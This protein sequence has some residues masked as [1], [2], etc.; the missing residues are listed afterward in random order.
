M[1]IR[2]CGNKLTSRFLDGKTVKE[3]QGIERQATKAVTRLQAAV[4]LSDLRSPPGNNLEALVGD[5]KGQHSIRIND[6]WRLCFLWKPRTPLQEGE[7][8]MNIPGDAF[9]VEIIDYH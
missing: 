6:R 1:I 2:P 9:D 3:F 8:I 5:R 7:N 4:R